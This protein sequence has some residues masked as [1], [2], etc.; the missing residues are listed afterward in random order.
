LRNIVKQDIIHYD[1][2]TPRRVHLAESAYVHGAK[3][4]TSSIFLILLALSDRERH[5]LG[6]ADEIESRT[7]GKVRVG[8]GTL[9]NAIRKMSE[10]GL[11]AEVAFAPDPDDDDPRRR[12]YRITSLGRR[13]MHEEVERLSVVLAMARQKA[14][15]QG[16]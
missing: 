14:V 12:Y 10:A 4:I 9:Y 15:P 16:E 6:I 2:S 13:R 8:P 3:P 5:G 11:I 7:Q 1:T